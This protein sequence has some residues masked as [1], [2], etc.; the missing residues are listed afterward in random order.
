MEDIK[1]RPVPMRTNIR[2]GEYGGYECAIEGKDRERRQIGRGLQRGIGRE[3]ETEGVRQVRRHGGSESRFGN[4]VL[5][6]R[7]GGTRRHRKIRHRERERRKGRPK[8]GK[9]QLEAA[10]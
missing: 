7:K 1:C 5:M 2:G 4:Q 6:R 3:K 8:T 10:K 9:R